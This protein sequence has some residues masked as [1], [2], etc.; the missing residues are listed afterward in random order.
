MRQMLI[1]AKLLFIILIVSSCKTKRPSPLTTE[2]PSHALNF[3]N[4]SWSIKAATFNVRALPVK[5]PK[6]K[7]RMGLTGVEIDRLKIDIIGMQEAF[8]TR[9]K[10][11]LLKN[12]ALKHSH[13]FKV[14]GTLGSGNFIVS[15]TP[16]SDPTFYYHLL[17][18]P[19]KNIEGWSGKGIGKVNTTHKKLPISFFNVHLLARR[20][21]DANR[22]QDNN[23]IDRLIEIFEVFSQIVEQTESDAFILA[24]DFNMNMHNLEYAF[25]KNLTSLKGT[26]IQ[27][28][29]NEC[30]FCENNTFN[31]HEEGQL[32]YIWVSP[33]LKIDSSKIVFKSPIRIKHEMMNLSDHF[34]I[35]SDI[36]I[37]QNK[38]IDPA[39][40]RLKTTQQIDWLYHRTKRYLQRNYSN[41]KSVAEKFC[42]KCR[43]KDTLD[44]LKLYK[45]ALSGN[46]TLSK[47]E[48][49]IKRRLD[50]YFSLF[51]N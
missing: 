30:T 2:I 16:V 24:G 11:N 34:G 25:F 13:F 41:E 10:K 51:S 36:S 50:S 27:E 14:P 5:S 44:H 21:R 3:E 39:T 42:R 20:G 9:G 37:N 45:M 1:V 35:L 31:N 18:G 22:W 17:L 28:N 33:R 47:K 23:S 43:I 12:T 26:L 49:I 8:I 29:R 6:A 46:K 7:K 38:Y 4:K 15:K 40:V 32:D 19:L 48:S